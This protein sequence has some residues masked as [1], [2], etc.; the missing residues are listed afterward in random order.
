M[1]GLYFLGYL[2]LEI[3]F[4][5]EFAKIFTPFGLFLEVIFSAFIGV[6]IIRT[7]QFSMFEEMQRVMRREITQEEFVT[8]GMF[9][10]IG[11]LFLII[12]GVFSDML[13]VLFLLEPFAR[14]AAKKLFI[15]NNRYYEYQNDYKPQRDDDI[16]DVEIVEII[17]KKP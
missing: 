8:S 16:I 12:P 9:K 15:A 3:V 7:L 5:Y 10:L 14:W 4:S 13:G 11:A 1:G 17:D 2:F 6:Y